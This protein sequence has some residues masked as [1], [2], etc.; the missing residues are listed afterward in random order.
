MRGGLGGRFTLEL[1]LVSTNVSFRLE[2]EQQPDRALS[3]ERGMDIGLSAEGSS[4]WERQKDP[5][6]TEE[7]EFLEWLRR[8]GALFHDVHWPSSETE[9]GMRGA[10]ATRNIDSGVRNSDDQARSYG[11]L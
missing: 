11:L 4:S 10:I 5:T 3:Y 8:N 2:V 1:S 9:S 7:Q 6:S